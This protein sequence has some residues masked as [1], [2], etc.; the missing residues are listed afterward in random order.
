M[1]R[2]AIEVIFGHPKWL[3][4]AIKKKTFTKKVSRVICTM[5]EPTAGRLQ[6]DIN[7]PLV[8]IHT[9]SYVLERGSIHCVRPL[10]RMQTILVVYVVIQVC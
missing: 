6:L 9:D 1:V 3:P 7:S 4:A 5:F 2:N 10:G 8:N